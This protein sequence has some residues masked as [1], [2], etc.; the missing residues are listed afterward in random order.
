MVLSVLFQDTK[1]IAGGRTFFYFR[2]ILTLQACS[3]INY[4]RTH[5]GHTA[6]HPNLEPDGNVELPDQPAYHMER[7]IPESMAAVANRTIS[8][9]LYLF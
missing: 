7:M 4:N 5:V 3:R 6:I 8:K 1:N 2:K 9:F